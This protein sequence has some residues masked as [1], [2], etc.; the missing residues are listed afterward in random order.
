MKISAKSGKWKVSDIEVLFVPMAEKESVPKGLPKVA[1]QL[2]KDAIAQKEF[3]GKSN[4]LLHLRIPLSGKK[5]LRHIFAIGAGKQHSLNEVDFGKLVGQAIRQAQALKA[6][7]V[8]FWYRDM[9]EDHIEG[10]RHLSEIV[11]EYAVMAGYEFGELKKKKLDQIK[12][13]L[14]FAE[15]KAELKAIQQGIKVGVTIASMVNESRDLCNR[16]SNKARPK[17]IAAFAKEAAKT[18]AALKVK[19]LGEKEMH[20]LGM[21]GV[22]GVS[23]GSINEGQFIIVEYTGGEKSDQPYV[24]VGKGVTFDTGGI[25]IKPSRGMEEMKFDMCGAAAALG[26]VRSAAALELPLN[27][28]A[29]VPS[30]ENMPGQ[31]AYKPGDVLTALDGSTIEVLN[32][33]AEGRLLLADA[34]V[35]ARDYKPQAVVDLAT[36]TGACAVALYD[37]AAGMFTKEDEIAKG[38]EAASASTGDVAWRMPFPERYNEFMKSKVADIANIASV[39]YGGAITAGAFL[40]HFVADKYPWAHLDIA[41]VAWNP[42]GK[43]LAQGAT[44]AGIRVCVEWLRSLA[45]N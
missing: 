35:Y 44:G 10:V 19:V 2:L 31:N 43:H 3:A 41:G 33:D 34:L 42:G 36:L 21:G 13:M 12:S 29:L 5:G 37:S 4:Q 20:K 40:R 32:T 15:N 1:E 39:P 30:A 24:F 38:L 18:D 27:V 7:Q 23:Q 6:S 9:L 26:I 11:A 45:K 28:V 17:D 8:G 16:P 14:V 25:S 22:L